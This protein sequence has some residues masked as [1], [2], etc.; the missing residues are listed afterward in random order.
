MGTYLYGITRC[1][2]PVSAGKGGVGDPPA[3]VRRLRFGDLAAL[4]SDV[5][6]DAVGEAAGV[7]G[8]RRDM[9]AHSDLLNRLIAETTVLP[10]RFGVI[11]PEDRTLIDQLLDPEHDQLL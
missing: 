10:V 1:D 11:F 3:R 7:R 9:A 4:V 8:M 2:V 5:D 6:D